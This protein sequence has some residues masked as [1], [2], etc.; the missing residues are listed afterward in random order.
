MKQNG[1]PTLITESTDISF[2][3]IS[4]VVNLDIFSFVYWI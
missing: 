1:V 2:D 4:E 3:S